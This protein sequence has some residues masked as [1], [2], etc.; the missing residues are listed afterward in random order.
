VTNED[1]QV[2]EYLT[3]LLAGMD[4][5]DRDQ[6]LPI[7]QLTST[8]GEMAQKTIRLRPAA[9]YMQ[10]GILNLRLW[11]NQVGLF[12]IPTLELA[13]WLFERHP[14]FV[15][16]CHEIGAGGAV[17]AQWTGHGCSDARYNQG[18]DLIA[19]ALGSR[20]AIIPTWVP[21]AD[22]TT[23]VRQLR[24]RVVLAQ[25]VTPGNVAGGG[26]SYGPDYAQVLANCEELIF[27]GNEFT[28]GECLQNALP[29]ADEEY[30]P[31]WLLSRGKYN[32][33][34]FIYIW[35]GSLHT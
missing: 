14:N 19:Q 24:P 18:A 22:G 6:V 10:H 28:H 23:I 2:A 31:D 21:Q 33:R 34:N 1:A 7:D 32:D 27:I 13:T 30:R 26:N 9:D 4:A 35:K 20:H 3:R 16:D 12:S 15:Q 11:A 8:W 29:P 25:W 17:L 5:V